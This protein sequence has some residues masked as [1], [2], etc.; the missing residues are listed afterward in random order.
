MREQTWDL[1]ILV[2]LREWHWEGYGRVMAT[3]V[4][5]YGRELLAVLALRKDGTC[6]SLEF[7]I[8][9]LVMSSIC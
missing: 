2:R 7:T 1:I 4:T 8:V 6:I 3:G 9:L 5:R